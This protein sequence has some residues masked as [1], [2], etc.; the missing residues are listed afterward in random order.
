M[1]AKTSKLYRKFVKTLGLP[2]AKVRAAYQALKH[3][4]ITCNR[5]D[6]ASLTA[7]MRNAPVI[8]QS[9]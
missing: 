7:G 9:K 3:R 5:F 6:K 2:H 8:E 1:N 4:H